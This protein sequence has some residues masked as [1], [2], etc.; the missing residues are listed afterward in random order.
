MQ[1]GAVPNFWE[2]LQIP[3]NLHIIKFKLNLLYATS[4]PV[5]SLA[6]LVFFADK[7]WFSFY[8]CGTANDQYQK[9][10]N[11]EI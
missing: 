2:T 5:F 11:K 8:V 6:K 3:K 9:C 1:I 7:Q 4:Y 10:V